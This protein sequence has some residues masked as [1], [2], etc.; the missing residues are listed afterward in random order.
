MNSFLQNDLKNLESLFEIVARQGLDYLTNIAELPTSTNSTIHTKEK[1]PVNGFGSVEVLKVFNER[2][3][4]IMAATSGPRF[5]GFVTGGSTPA[6]IM[7]DWLTSIYDQ[8]SFATNGQG[9]ISAIIEL[10]T[11]KLL[12]D[13]FELP[14]DF[15]GGFVTGATM[16]NFTCLAVARQWAGKEL[17]KDFAKEGVSGKIHILSASPHSSSVKSLSMLGIGSN[18]I[19]KV[20][21]AAGNREAIDMDD[22]KKTIAGLNGEPFILISS[23]GTV[24]TVDFDDFEE[25]SKLKSTHHFWWHIDAAFGGFAACTASHKHLVKGWENADSITVDCHK[26]LN[27]PYESAVFFVKEKHKVLQVET[28][29]N[30]NAP[31]LGDPNENFSY[32]NFLPE[33]SRRLKALPAWFSLMA[34]GKQ[35][36]RDIVEMNIK[37]AHQFESFIEKNNQF[38]LLAPVRLN[39]VCF[40]LAGE[41]GQEK[42]NAFLTKLNDTQQVFMTP[43]VYNGSKGIRAAFVNWRTTEEDITQVTNLMTAIITELS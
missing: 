43:T 26:W 33:N 7:G 1:L 31:Y 40:T 22:L 14:A 18:H 28:F 34:Y 19:I 11:I 8:N 36:Y 5:W 15:L 25:I 29:Q 30:S 37:L 6:S 2:F 10:E 4:P 27:V 20:K 35:G 32:L 12:L 38:E 21:T 42:V 41:D 9:D 3:E 23:G 13:L 24:N 39:T 17:G 16:S